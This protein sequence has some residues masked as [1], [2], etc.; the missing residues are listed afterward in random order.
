LSRKQSDDAGEGTPMARWIA[1]VSAWLLAAVLAAGPSAAQTREKVS[2]AALAFVSSSPIFIALDRGHFAAEGL[3]V[4]IKFFT[5]AGPVALA[6]ASGDADFGITGLT[7]AF[8]NLAGKGA[9]KIVAAQSREEPGYDF[10]AYVVS[11]KAYDAG[12]HSVAQYPG[13]TVGITTVGST[14]HYNLGKLAEK[15]GFKLEQVTLKPL[16]SI[17]NVMAALQGSQVDSVLLPAN[18]ALALEREGAG[19][20]IGW[21]HQETP[22]QLGALFASSRNVETRRAI[23]EKFVRGYQKGAADY[24]RAFLQRDAAGKRVFGAEAEA[25]FPILKKYVK[26]EPTLERVKES[27]NFIDPEGRLLVQ[28]IYDQVA[29]YKA[30][31]LVD[32]D[33][34]PKAFLDLGFVKGHLQLPKS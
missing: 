9:L 2:V 12:F 1:F 34:D 19:K 18:N 17:P 30:Q 16:Q 33:V 26:P 31:G 21:V 15:R 28:D 27:A 14:F 22:W 3:D 8:Y 7:G 29:W 4:E 13:K 10:V 23:V 20:I 11:K 25:L 5:A 24:A 32:K 6:V